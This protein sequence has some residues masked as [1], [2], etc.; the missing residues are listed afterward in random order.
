VVGR[1]PCGVWCGGAVVRCG[2]GGGS[3]CCP[4]LGPCSAAAFATGAAAAVVLAL[5]LPLPVAAAGRC[6]AAAATR[7]GEGGRR[8]RVSGV[9]GGGLV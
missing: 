3:V 1:R 7:R 6:P 2:V 5:P 8:T 4:P 9:L